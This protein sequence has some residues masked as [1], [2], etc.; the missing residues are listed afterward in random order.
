MLAART[1]EQLDE[2][3]DDV[4][5]FGRRALVIPCDVNDNDALED[6]VAQTMAEFGRID[7]V[8]NNA[9]GTMPR[10]FMDTSAGYLERA[11]HFN[12]TTAFVLTKAARRT[13]SPRARARSS[14][15]RPRSAGCA[16][17]ASSRTARPRP[18]SRT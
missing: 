8:V 14:T 7:V 5:G 4:R 17:A 13:C 6:I 9:G 2:V 3:A 12:C 10:P 18:R 16:T 15:S 1:K 11:F